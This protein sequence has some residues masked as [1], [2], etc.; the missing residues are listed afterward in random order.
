M[1]SIWEK[2]WWTLILYINASLLIAQQGLDGNRA[3]WFGTFWHWELFGA[4]GHTITWHAGCWFYGLHCTSCIEVWRFSHLLEI[5][6]D[7]EQFLCS[8]HGWITFFL[9]C[10][11]IVAVCDLSEDCQWGSPQRRCTSGAN[12]LWCF[13]CVCGVHCVYRW[14]CWRWSTC[15]HRLPMASAAWAG[16]F[17]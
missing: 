8:Q 6:G 3:P 11:L 10:G 12:V 16:V 2:L 7:V 14:L 4:I 5:A 1:N 17:L 9:V 13:G 15:G